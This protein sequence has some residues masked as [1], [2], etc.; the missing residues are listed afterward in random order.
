MQ[1][2]IVDNPPGVLFLADVQPNVFYRIFQDGQAHEIEAGQDVWLADVLAGAGL[3]HPDRA[4]FRISGTDTWFPIPALV[5]ARAV[6][7]SWL[8]SC[9]LAA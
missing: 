4:D 6:R 9:Q 2:L 7:V 5:L 1:K 3:T 8:I